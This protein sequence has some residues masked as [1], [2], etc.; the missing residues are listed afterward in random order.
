MAL[1]L[2]LA[3]ACTS[4]EAVGEDCYADAPVALVGT[5]DATFEELAD[6][7]TVYMVTGSQ[8]GEHVYGSLRLW[9]TDDIVVVHYSIT[10]E[11]DGS[12][13]SDQTYR[14]GMLSEGDCTHEYVGMYGYLGF[15][16]D[17]TVSLEGVAVSLRIEATDSEDRSAADEVE[18]IIQK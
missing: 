4:E 18:V 11:D 7:D 3:A 8:G 17:Y 14:V 1:L 6:G 12:V 5:G 9:N 10:R 2:F 13:I 15:T 16:S